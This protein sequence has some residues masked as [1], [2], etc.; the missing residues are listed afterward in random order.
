MLISLTVFEVLPRVVENSNS[1]PVGKTKAL[2]EDL[3]M[4]MGPFCHLSASA[5]GTRC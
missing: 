2:L 3:N 1:Y 5:S 4:Q